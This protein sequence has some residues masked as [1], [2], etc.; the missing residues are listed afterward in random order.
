MQMAGA[1]RS[2]RITAGFVSYAAA[3][4]VLL[5]AIGRYGALAFA[6]S[7]RTK[8]IG[9]FIAVGA[10]STTVLAMV[11][12]EGIMA[13]AVGVLDGLVLA[14]AGTDLIR[15]HLYGSDA[16]DAIVYAA[17]AAVVVCVGGLFE[18]PTTSA[19]ATRCL[20]A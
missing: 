6:V 2:L 3:L 18:L 8:E 17:A 13:I 12:R 19:P 11:M 16:G 5:S 7:R 4:A 9:I 15:D 14:V 20:E 1:T 10:K